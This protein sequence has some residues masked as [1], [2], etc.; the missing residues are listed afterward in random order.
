MAVPKR[1]KNGAALNNLRRLSFSC[2]PHI[3]AGKQAVS[4]DLK[5]LAGTFRWQ[6]PSWHQ[7]PHTGSCP[8]EKCSRENCLSVIV[9]KRGASYDKDHLKMPSGV[10]LGSQGRRMCSHL[11]LVLSFVRAM[12]ETATDVETG[13]KGGFTRKPSFALILLE[14]QV[15]A[16]TKGA[17][18]N[19]VAMVSV[20]T[21][22][23]RSTSATSPPASTCLSDQQ[24]VFVATRLTNSKTAVTV[25]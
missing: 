8:W 15:I 14:I 13:Y 23:R 10:C 2:F 5:R 6:G 17:G 18:K 19:W 4:T 21:S 1:S 12:A 3:N 24:K 11:V 7:G 16:W 20:W 25:C 9:L 22:P